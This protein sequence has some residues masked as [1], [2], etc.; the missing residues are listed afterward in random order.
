MDV[1]FTTVANS[2]LAN[3]WSR[4]LVLIANETEVDGIYL[5]G[6]SYDSVTM[7]RAMRAVSAGNKQNSRHR[8]MH[9]KRT[10][11]S[12]HSVSGKVAKEK[13]SSDGMLD[14]HCGNRWPSGAGEINVLE[15]SRHM[16]LMDS[17]M[18]GE[19][20]DDGG[21]KACANRTSGI[22]GDATWM[23]LATSGL[24]FGVFNDML[25]GV[26]LFRGMV[27]G[28]AGRP[29]YS[30]AQQNAAL[31]RFWDDSGIASNR[32]ELL[33]FWSGGYGNGND[34]WVPVVDTGV[35]DVKASAYVIQPSTRKG[36]GTDT[37]IGH[38]VVAVASWAMV[39][40]KFSLILNH[41]VLRKKLPGW[42][43][44]KLKLSAP[45]IVHVQ[46]GESFAAIDTELALQ[47]R[48]GAVLLVELR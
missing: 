24:Q 18:M 46:N 19:G 2:R 8:H 34:A 15:Y 30:N 3:F 36:T 4:A 14:L 40:V 17:I 39:D 10:S 44:S 21:T 41:T 29:P 25:T 43:P 6:V 32:T 11:T 16:S 23:M 22:C 26:N 38:V 47:P 7:L 13:L 5:D 20:F 27:F 9:S 42:D 33:G 12:R 37:G 48:A 28:M 45:S 35:Q 31:Y 1:S